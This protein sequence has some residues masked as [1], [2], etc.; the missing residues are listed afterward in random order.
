MSDIS[1]LFG[2]I[3]SGG[4]SRRYGTDKAAILLE[5]QPLLERMVQIVSGAVD[6]LFVSVRPDQTEDALRNGYPLILDEQS[7]WGPAGGI[8]AAHGHEPSVAWLVVAC[9]LAYLDEAAIVAL[10]ASR[11]PDQ[12]ATG[13]RSPVDGLAE[14]LCAIWEPATLR[15]FQRQAITGGQLSPRAMLASVN[16]HL[17]DVAD[18]KKLV[19]IN[20]PADRPV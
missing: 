20:T 1:P 13:Y 6:H 7:G 10:I 11:Q 17:I 15:T 4:H 3:L 9:D 16:M 5:G 8:L 18:A 12:G 2:L 14:P 19:N